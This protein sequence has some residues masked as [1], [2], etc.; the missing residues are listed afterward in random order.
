MSQFKRDQVQDMYYLSPMQEGML[1]HTLHHQ[2]KGF[3]VEQMDMN[4]KGTLRSDLLEK[5]MNIIVER[6]DIFRTVFLHEKVKRPVQVVLKNR[7]F[8]LDI[9]DI[10]DLSES[11]QLERID[12]FKQKDQLRGFD[13]SKDLLMRASVFQT[14]P[15]SYRW[16]WS[17]HHIL[18]D[19]WCFG[20]VVQ[21]LFAI[22]HALL[23][24]IPYRLE[25]VKPYKEYIQWLE[26]Q[27]KQASLEYWTQSLAGFEG[28]STFKE[29]R[30][31]TNEHEL[32]EIEWAMSKEE[33][34][35]LSELALQ[36]NATLSSA[37]QSVW[38]ILLSR[39]QRSNDV[40]FGTVV[41]GR[42]ADLAGVD[43]MVGLFI[44]VIPRRIQLTDQMTFRSLLSETQQQSLAAEPHQ[45]IPIYDIQAKAGQQQ[46]IDHIVVFENVPVAKKDEQESLLGF[47]VEDMNVYEKSNY[48]LNLLASPGE[49][50]QLK[51]AFNQRAFD[52]AFVHKL[53]DQLTLL[54]KGT[55]KHPD[56][57]VHTL[58]LVTKQEKQRMLEEWNAP[59]LEHDQLYLT[60]WFEHNVRKQPNAVALSAGDHT[61][62]YAELNEQANRLARHLQKN[63]V[64]HQTVTAILA[65]RTPE[66]IVSLLAV[67]KA[68]ATYVPIDPDYPESRIQYMLKD[69]GATHLLTHSSFISQ[70]RSLAF[71]GTY[72]F[73]DDQEILLMSSENLP[74]EAG[75]DDTAYIMYTSGT[76]GQPKGIMTTHSNIARVVKNTNYLTILE[77]DT[78]LSLSN[79]VFDGFTFDVY[80]ALLNGA[81]LVLPQ[82]ET[83]LD[84][85]KLTELIKGE[86]ISVM[87]VPTA[88]FHL[89]VDEGTDWMRG[90]RKVLFGGE[91]ASVQHVRKAF[92]VMGKGR[93]LNVYGP[94]ESTVFATY[95]PIDEAIPLEARSIPIGKPLNQTG[96]YILSEHRQLQPI[97]MVGELCLSGKG[98][99]KGYLNRPDLTKQ[100][101]IAHPFAA[102]ERLYRT[103]DLAYF[104]EDGLI[105]YA[106]RVDDQVKI[107]G[108]RI[109]LTEI[110][111][112]LLMHP[113][114]KQAVLLADHDETNHT[115][116]LAYITCD[117]AWKGKLDDIKS[118]LKERLPAYMLPHE[119]IELENLPL[120]P[121]GKVDKRQ[122]PKPEAPQGNR[123]VKLPANEVEQKLLVMWREVLEREDISTDDHFFELGGHSLKA[124]SL[125]SKVSKEFEV[126]VPIHL[127]F[128]IPTIEA[129]SHYIQH[130]DG[131]TAGYLVFN[132]SQTSTVFALPPLPGYGFI[133]QEA[134][135]TLD[136]VR[137]VAFDFIETNNR[138]AQYVQHIQHLQPKGPLTLMGYSGGC[139]LAFELVQALEQ[140]GRTVEKVIMID[141][142]KK[143]GESDL[144]G[145]SIDD[146]IEAIVHQTKQSELA[147]GEIVQEALAQ[148]TRAYYETFVKGVN[149]GKI[150]ADITFIQSEEQIAIPDWMEEWT[151]ATAGSFTQYQGYGRHADMFK[152]KECAAQNAK[153]IKHIVNQTNRERVL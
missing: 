75:L 57:S 60:K 139:Y 116:L 46:L 72:L 136:D 63:G 99:A 90:V 27:D 133:Y 65:E 24:D 61:M 6:Y 93:L 59:E 51:L 81:K 83:I 1:F 36:Q 74:L 3:Y 31:Q 35:A 10:Q 91:R 127:L 143:I 32:G 14:G 19:G 22:Y 42:P 145:R 55:I 108:H 126:Q 153:L 17:Y 48:D 125:L 84:M 150:Q 147:Q 67:L 30:K 111:A 82:K 113:G 119:L 25:P 87:F 86:H 142:Y 29:Q 45:Y 49:Q 41:S 11:E 50:L 128:E 43:R 37:L 71:D 96:A 120:T 79:S 26:K 138:M 121:N 102:G 94:T 64:E 13:L 66:L 95:Y 2:E 104:R 109:E 80:G 76:T 40:L 58:T 85:G 103:G 114:V 21:E 5:S 152:Q 118:G 135:K 132:E 100:V 7:P 117:D 134:A 70:T 149:Q 54:I 77:T 105:E 62:T 123:R 33:T 39:Y 52:P 34:A 88:L 73:A 124:M 107:R 47:T 97:G 15:S 110:E 23:H 28:Q 4:V 122:L 130:Q 101:F 44:N 89:L 78:L 18:L 140:V 12:R 38:S 53:K 98:L 9:V 141:S 69:S 112:N 144:E 148:K 8:Q 131:E 68:G 106:G 115:R 129:L 151:Q 16:I 92:D 137:L 20:L 56:Q 146:D